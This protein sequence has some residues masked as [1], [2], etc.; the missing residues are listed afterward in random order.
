[1]FKRKFLAEISFSVLFLSMILLNYGTYFEFFFTSKYI[2]TSDYV[3]IID[4][5]KS[6][7]NKRLLVLGENLSP[8]YGNTMATP[9]LNWKLSKR[10][11][12]NMQYYDNLTMILTGF[13]KD[14]PEVIIDENNIM[15]DILKHIP[16]LKERYRKESSS[17]Y[18]LTEK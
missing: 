16:Y 1:M 13:K 4:E 3:V 14:M 18:V 5:S 7:K 2:D 11:F 10:V 17:V 15:P 9:F 8:Y 6:I 12:T